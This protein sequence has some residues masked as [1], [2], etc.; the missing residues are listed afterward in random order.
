MLPTVQEDM[1]VEEQLLVTIPEACLAVAQEEALVN[2][3]HMLLTP[4]MVRD[5]LTVQLRTIMALPIHQIKT[6]N[7][8]ISVSSI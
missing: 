6:K 5:Q 3:L 1:V 2:P 4:T 7:D 8:S